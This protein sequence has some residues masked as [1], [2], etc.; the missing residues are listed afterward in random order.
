VCYKHGGNNPGPVHPGGI[1]KPG[2]TRVSAYIATFG[3][4][5]RELVE[6]PDILKSEPE[7]ALFDQFLLERKDLLAGG[8][9]TAWL[10]SLAEAGV[11][12]RA[13]W[14]AQ[15][16]KR[17]LAGVS[18]MERLIQEGGERVA[19]WQEVLGAAKSRSELASKAAAAL[20]RADMVMTEAQMIVILAR[21][22]EIVRDVAGDQAAYAVG[23]RFERETL[24]GVVPGQGAINPS[25]PPATN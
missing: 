16:G 22:M 17:V 15:D 1:P 4:R 20:Q 12:V 7:I 14:D 9:S 11:A 23:S 18:E 25:V 6:D 5:F 24:R 21:L 3:D 8:F 19:A 2:R 13:G 10:K